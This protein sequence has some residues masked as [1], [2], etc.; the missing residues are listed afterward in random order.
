MKKTRKF[1]LFY[2]VFCSLLFSFLLSFS[3]NGQM[4]Q[5]TLIISEV[6]VSTEQGKV[7]YGLNHPNCTG[8]SYFTSNQYIYRVLQFPTALAKTKLLLGIQIL[9]EQLETK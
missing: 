9:M 3:L 5:S 4:Q 8:K 7:N 2:T 1:F 6:F